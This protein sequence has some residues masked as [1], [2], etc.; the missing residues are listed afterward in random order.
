[1]KAI[2]LAALAFAIGAVAQNSTQ[3][4]ANP[5]DHSD[6]GPGKS[7]FAHARQGA[8]PAYLN[9]LMTNRIPSLLLPIG[10]FIAE[11]ID[12]IAT[13]GASNLVSSAGFGPPDSLY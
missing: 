3:S 10:Y 8:T 7:T 13:A 11:D 4:K 1:M 5:P 12:Y 6:P 9:A 2:L